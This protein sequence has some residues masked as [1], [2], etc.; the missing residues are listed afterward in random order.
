[1]YKRLQDTLPESRKLGK[2]SDF[3]FRCW[4]NGLAKADWF[5]R[6][7]ADP[8]KFRITCFA[9]RPKVSDEEIAAALDELDT[10]GAIH[11][12][13]VEEGRYM[14]YHRHEE[15]NPTGGLKT[16]PCRCP[17]PPARTCR[18]VRYK[19]GE[20]AKSVVGNRFRFFKGLF[21]TDQKAASA[22][23]CSSPLLSSQEVG[24]SGGKEEEEPPKEEEERTVGKLCDEFTHLTGRVPFQSV[25]DPMEMMERLR[26]LISVRGLEP[27]LKV[28]REKTSECQQRTGRPPS[29][30]QYF[31]PIFEDERLFKGNGGMNEGASQVVRHFGLAPGSLDKKAKERMD[32]RNK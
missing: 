16:R 19:Q 23:L 14:V 3:A 9:N 30:M 27:M 13:E 24:G 5:G 7:A 32:A 11:L 18:C 8:D 22:P 1:M 28:M 12:Y 26:G 2:L 4:V 17:A 20:N 31:M 10:I 15:S 21:S 29:S 6:L 25:G